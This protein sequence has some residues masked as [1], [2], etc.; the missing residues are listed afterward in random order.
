MEKIT[1]DLSSLQVEGDST[2]DRKLLIAVDF[3]TTF[4]GVAWAQ[5]RRVCYFKYEIHFEICSYSQLQQPDVQ[6][7]IIQWPD[8]TTGGLEGVSS[9]KVPT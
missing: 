9:D 7:V 6:S 2:A 4:S 1:N 8:A 3:G 5:T